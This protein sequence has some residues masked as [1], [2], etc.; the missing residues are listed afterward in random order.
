MNALDQIFGGL[1]IAFGVTQSVTNFRI[2][3]SS[4]LTLSLSGTAAGML[5]GS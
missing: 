4:H 5:A 3:S 1:M 2:Q